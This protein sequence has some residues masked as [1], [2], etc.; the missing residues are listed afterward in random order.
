MSDWRTYKLGELVEKITKGTTPSTLGGGF[1]DNGINFIK[2]E[3]VTYDGT[4]DKSKFAYINK[5][6]HENLKRSQLQKD[7]ILFSMAGIFLGKNA[8]VTED[9]LPANTNQALAIIRLKKDITSV[10]YIHYYL[11]QADVVKKINSIS[12][13]SA[14]PN[15]NFEEI[16][17]IE[18][19]VPD[20]KT[21]KEIASIL[22]SLDDK[23]E[24]NRQMNQ[25]LEAMAQAIFKKWFVL[26]NTEGGLPDGWRMEKIS[27][28]GTVVTGNTPSSNNPEHFGSKTPFVTP[29]DFKNYGKLI[30]DSE[31]F[32]SDEGVK[33]L[34][35]RLLPVNSVIV[36]CIGSDMGKVAINKVECVTNQQINSIIPQKDLITVDYLY[37]DLVNKYEYLKNLSTGGSTMPIINKT[38]FEQIEI[39]VPTFDVVSKFQNLIDSFN[40]RI[41]DNIIQNKTL[42]QI[43]DSLL[44]KL[45]TGKITIER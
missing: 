44:P 21:Q 28:L 11:R 20:F 23:I 13:Q 35:K 32:L 40:N 12:G 16:K 38:R 19:K 33:A 26:P 15:I 5:E 30:I 27:N 2:S 10:K 14:Q 39:L 17:S 24:L 4:I 18:I 1:V 45:M 36:T 42:T 25:T 22:S 37:Y 31:R 29:S 43:R 9:I 6:T 8:I 7:D 3:S 41:E 34:S